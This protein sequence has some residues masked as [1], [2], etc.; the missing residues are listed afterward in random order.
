[1][2]DLNF[3]IIHVPTNYLE[4]NEQELYKQKC[5]ILLK[6]NILAC[7]LTPNILTIKKPE[8]KD[9]H[10]VGELVFQVQAKHSSIGKKKYDIYQEFLGKW[11]RLCSRSNPSSIVVL[12]DNSSFHKTRTTCH[13]DIS[14]NSVAFGVLTYNGI[15]QKYYSLN[16]YASLNSVLV[17]FFH[18]TRNLKIRYLNIEFTMS[19]NNI[20]NVFCD[21]TSFS[22][23]IYLDL[24][25]PPLVFKVEHKLSSKGESY[26]INH[27]TMALPN[28]INIDVFGRSNVMQISLAD[29]SLLEEIVSRIHFCCNKKPVHYTHIQQNMKNPPYDVPMNLPSFGCTYLLTAILKRNF[30]MAAQTTDVTQSIQELSLLCNQ[31]EQCLEKA[32]TVV[33]AALD[34]GK[35]INYWHAIKSQFQSYTDANENE[36]NYTN[37]I[38]PQNCRMIRRVTITPSRLLLWAPEIMFSNRVI[39]KFDS[40]YALRVSFRDDNLSKLSFQALFAEQN[41]FDLAIR[42]P[43]EYGFSIGRRQYKFLAWSNSQIREHGIWMY[44][45][46]EQGN[47]VQQIRSWMGNFSHIHSVSKYMARIGQCFSQTEETVS[48]PLDEHRIRLEK[49]IK[50]GFD[51]VHFDIYCFSDGVGKISEK[52]AKEVHEVLG[53]D[54]LCSAFQIRYGGYKGMLVIDPTLKDAD[55][56]FRYS[57]K[58]FDSPENIKL[59]IAKTSSPIP[60]KLNRPFITILNDMGVRHRTFLKLQEEMLKDLTDMLFDEKKATA[61]LTCHTP[62]Q[63]FNYKDLSCSRIYLTTEPFFRSLLLA[64]HRHHIEKLKNKANIPIDPSQGRNMLGVL[65]ETGRLEEGEVFV[66]YTKDISFG[67]TTRDTE[68]LERTVLVTK[69]PCLLPGDVR[70]FKAVNIPELRHIVDCIVFPQKGQRPLQNKMAGSDLDGDEYSVLWKDELIFHKPNETPGNFPSPIQDYKEVITDKDITEFL[71]TYIKNDQIGTI[72]NTHLALADQFDIFH[73]ICIAVAKKFSYA[74]DYAKTAVKTSMFALSRE[75]RPKQFPDFME[76]PHKETYKSKKALGKMFRVAHD[77]E[78]ENEHASIAY[79]DIEIDEDLKYPGWEKYKEDAIKSRNKYDTLLKT[80]LRNY[81]IQ[82]EAE[83]FSGAFTKLHCRFRERKDKEEIEKVVVG[84]I[85][86]LIK[87]FNAEFHEEFQK[88]TD[89]V[90][91]ID[92]D[93]LKKA[94]AWYVV[95]YSDQ[96]AEY[97]SFPWTISKYLALIKI[98]KTGSSSISISPIV[99]KMDQQIKLCESHNLLPTHTTSLWQNYEFVCDRA[100]VEL[101]LRVLLLWAQN[102]DVVQKPGKSTRGLLYTVKFVDLFFHIAKTAKYIKRKGRRVTADKDQLFS[103]AL[104]CIEFFRFCLTL[105]FYNKFEVK[106]LVQNGQTYKHELIKALAKRA[107]VSYH[108]LAVMGRFESIYF[109]TNEAENQIEMREVYK[110]RK[111]FQ[112]VDLENARDILEKCSQAQDVM[113]REV[114]QTKKVIVSAVGS[115]QSLK[116]LRRILRK[117]QDYLQELFRTGILPERKKQT[118]NSESSEMLPFKNFQV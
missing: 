63:L 59:E 7:G 103:P 22:H 32:L 5:I 91:N 75:E 71:I 84:C 111:C 16:Q 92:E 101:A 78:S 35:I 80:V 108:M 10:D 104:L 77:Y 23:Q 97:L 48:V 6:E 26:N 57:M 21:T 94:S 50:G 47:T 65:D 36:L 100:I 62:N 82:H 1:M 68:I 2:E 109:D 69:N 89:N 17:D 60:L 110:D 83:I 118:M 61:F 53:H 25:N 93:V 3:Q 98:K 51:P 67:E 54:K 72:A 106:E 56:V 33:L 105:R 31:N 64:L 9:Y 90:K 44:A 66:Q 43:A 45:M 81:G 55:I 30:T 49:D 14:C 29:K 85:K 11:N 41:I 58:K 46:D 28:C 79:H 102:E 42:K 95:T 112:G 52:L 37:Y 18:D 38:V 74:V 40:D 27:L 39:R 73:P 99:Q 88:C 107:L 12:Y 113:L 96:N 70:K 13:K 115:E 86:Q 19:Y 114:L 24:C 20:R 4:K 87:S 34:S 15:F 76:K 8:D 116:A 117:N